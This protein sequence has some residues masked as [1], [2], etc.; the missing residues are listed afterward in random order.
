MSCLLRLLVHACATMVKKR[1]RHSIILFSE[2]QKQPPGGAPRK[3]CSENMQQIYRRTP[4]P[5]HDSNKV[6]KQLYWDCTLALIFSCKIAVCFHKNTS[7]RLLVIFIRVVG[8][9]Y[10]VTQFNHSK[11]RN[12]LTSLK[13]VT[14]T[15]KHCKIN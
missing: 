14:N 5:K 7:G 12:F 3:S 10:V 15:I 9:T 1:V 11:F 4:M 2:I 6:A 8:V 13:M